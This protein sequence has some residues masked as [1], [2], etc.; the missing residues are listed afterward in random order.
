MKSPSPTR[1][2]QTALAEHNQLWLI[3]A[4]DTDPWFKY[5][6]WLTQYELTKMRPRFSQTPD[7]W[8]MSLTKYLPAAALGLCRFS[9]DTASG[10]RERLEKM[11][12]PKTA[13][14][15]PDAEDF[16]DKISINHPQRFYR[17]R[18]QP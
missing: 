16:Y 12:G 14:F 3:S 7:L 11:G 1:D 18:R 5:F 13:V 9:T 2:L 10:L 6:D 15:S 4:D 17:V 8:I